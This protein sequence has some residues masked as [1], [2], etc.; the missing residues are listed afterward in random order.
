MH[1]RWLYIIIDWWYLVIILGGWGTKPKE[2]AARAASSFVGYLSENI[3]YLTHLCVSE[4]L[5]GCGTVDQVGHMMLQALA[6]AH[7]DIVIDK[8]ESWEAGTTTLLGI[9]LVPMLVCVIIHNF[10][11]TLGRIYTSAS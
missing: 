6:E 3:A 7:N 2:A 5:R 9:T 10:I 4:C 11:S 1:C 8:S